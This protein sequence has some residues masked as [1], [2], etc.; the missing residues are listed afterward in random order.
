M[1]HN[2]NR[3]ILG[4]GLSALLSDDSALKRYEAADDN[5]AEQSFEISVN[6][7]DPNPW[8]PRKVISEKEV[9]ELSESIKVHGVIQPIVLRKSGDRYQIIAGERRW[10]ASQL[11]GMQNIPAHVV[12]LADSEMLEVALIE[13][14][15]RQNL[16][17][18][19]EAK[20]FESLL[21]KVTQLEVSKRVGKSRSYIANS[22]RLLTLPEDV[23]RK[24]V[25]REISIGHARALIGNPNA[26]EAAQQISN[27][28]M[29]VRQVERRFNKVEEK[30]R[31]Q[32]L[33][34]SLTEDPEYLERREW[35]DGVD[36]IERALTDCLG[37]KVKIRDNMEG[38]AMIIEFFSLEQLDYLTA[39]LSG[40]PL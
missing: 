3:K 40:I 18:I 16:N 38:G 13:N 24:L 32:R 19:D 10:R 17:P 36:E 11:I 27:E 29:N 9:R 12:E 15:Q 4:R 8:Q 21:Q 33:P 23:Q 28:K 5:I 2:H 30:G 14:I 34:F 6:A 22:V 20:A 25:N 1:Q 26:S 31:G 7:I 35:K 39:R 37:L